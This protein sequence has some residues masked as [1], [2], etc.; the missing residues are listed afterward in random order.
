M[1]DSIMTCERLDTM[2]ANHLEGDLDWRTR[3]MVESH[4]SECLRCAALVRDLRA[5]ERDARELPELEPS[6]DLWAGIAER[7]ETPVIALGK[8]EAPRAW[9]NRPARLAAAAVLLVAGTAGTTYMLSRNA[10]SHDSGTRVASRI[11]SGITAGA[12]TASTPNVTPQGSRGVAT[13]A[14]IVRQKDLPAVVTY[15]RE[16]NALRGVLELR[17]NDLDPAT[18]AVLENSLQTIDHAIADAKAAIVKDS[19]SAFLHDQLNKAL[20]KKLG[21]LRTVALLPPRA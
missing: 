6:R 12:S 3:A 5:I 10:N 9:L 8:K 11:D 7:I 1:N 18:V 2:L 17:R 19:A 21:L 15:D 20:E 14:S 16:I 4:L 13:T